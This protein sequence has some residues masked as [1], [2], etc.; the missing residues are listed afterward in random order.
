MNGKEK[1]NPARYRPVYAILLVAIA[2]GML[3]WL[4]T[5]DLEK[6]GDDS[7]PR[8]RPQN[9]DET[10]S[11]RDNPA[12]ATKAEPSRIKKTNSDKPKNLF[13]IARA[14]RTWRPAFPAVRRLT[15]C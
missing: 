11:P 6:S 3:V 12:V 9:N 8:E 15:L 4:V 14:A 7:G 5:V 13:A 2:V 1:R 10:I